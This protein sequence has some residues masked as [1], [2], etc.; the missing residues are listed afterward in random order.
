MINSPHRR[1][2]ALTGE[3][4]LVSPHRAKRPWL[5]QVEKAPIENLPTYDPTCYLCPRNERAGGVTNPDYSGT[6]TFDNDFAALLPDPSVEATST[7]P[8]L[9]SVPERGSCRVVC[10]SPRHDLTL[11]ELDLTSIEKVIATWTRESA[12]LAAQDFIRYVQVFE[13]KGAMMGCSNPHPHSQLWAQSQLPNEIIKEQATQRDYYSQHGRP[14]LLDYVQEELKLKERI[15][16]SNEHF[17]ALVPFWAVW[18]FETMVIAHRATQSL[19]DLTAA[20][21]SALA[22]AFKQVTTRYDNLFEISFPYSM[23]FHQA[24]ADGEAHPEWVLHAHFYPP[25]LRSAT[26]R[27]FMVGYEMLAMPQRDI[28]PEVATERLRSV[29]DVHY[30]QRIHE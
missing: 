2:N 5:G 11:P 22:E 26:V 6:F 23:G 10:F 12:D 27:K 19:S 4:V 16:F 28:T 17:T 7:H 18:P 24:P 25:L 8:L 14:L 1:F 13:N 15:L 20:E 9:V 29:S 30:K 21:V 3:W